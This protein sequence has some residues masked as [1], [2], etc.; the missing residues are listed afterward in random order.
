[1][2]WSMKNSIRTLLLSSSL[3]SLTAI[4]SAEAL[5]TLPSYDLIMDGMSVGQMSFRTRVFDDGHAHCQYTG[6]WTG[7]SGSLTRTR[8]CKLI[9]Y[10]A[11]DNFDCEEN[12][13][14][15]FNTLVTLA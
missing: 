12:Q 3:L 15:F 14:T 11:G 4:P 10:H 9:E 1:R 7:P 6:R 8:L 5:S 13:R 2:F